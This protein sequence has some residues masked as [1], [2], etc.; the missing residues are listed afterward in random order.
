MKRFCLIS[1][2]FCL[3]LTVV[4]Q[5]FSENKNYYLISV[6]ILILSMLPFFA[7]FEKKSH[8]SRQI[9]LV[10]SLVAIAVVS[11]AVFYLIPQ[12]KPIAAVV[13]VSAACLGAEKGYLIGAFSAFISNFIFGQ[14]IWTPFQMVA[15]G[16]TGL[17]AGLLFSKIKINKI[18]LSITGFVLAF[19]VYGIIVDASSVLMM[20][21]DLS[22]ASVASV[23]A[24][25][26]P[27]SLVFG[28]STAVFLFLFGV[29]F[30][31]K[32]ERINIKYGIYEV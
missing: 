31:K 18:N 29:P 32:I 2:V 15:L 25:G 8:T 6:I 26:V 13:I 20:S 16:F 17:I 28:I 22:I 5:I 23:Y 24:A 4:W 27:F 14:G 9:T 10:A 21:S 1:A 30:A 7:S 11:R 19:I 3:V 12:V